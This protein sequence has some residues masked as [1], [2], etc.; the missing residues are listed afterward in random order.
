MKLKLKCPAC[1]E[2]FER[3]VSFKGWYTYY[4]GTNFGL[5]RNCDKCLKAVLKIGAGQFS[6]HPIEEEQRKE[7]WIKFRDKILEEENEM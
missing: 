7:R 1:L 2:N 6:E 4:L 3:Q 5:D